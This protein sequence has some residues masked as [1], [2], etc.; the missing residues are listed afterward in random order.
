MADELVEIE[1][2]HW[3]KLRDLYLPKIPENYISYSILEAYTRWAEQ[4]PES[5]D[6]VCYSLNGD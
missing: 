1:R 4:D 2:E 5:A 6:M 3:P